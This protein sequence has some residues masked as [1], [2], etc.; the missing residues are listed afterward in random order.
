MLLHPVLHKDG[1]EHCCHHEVEAATVEME[2]VAEDGTHR[3]SRDPV[4]IVEH[5][6]PEHEPAFVDAFRD[7]CCIIDG[8]R[9]VA[10]AVDEREL[11]PA[12]ACSVVRM[13]N[14]CNIV[15]KLVLSFQIETF[16]A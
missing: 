2:E 6:D 10:H 7:L 14:A 12:H 1:D 4:A 11:F 15:A 16:F 3:R 5:G 9:L 8:E 13:Y